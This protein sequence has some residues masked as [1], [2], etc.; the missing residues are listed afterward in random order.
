MDSSVLPVTTN[1][2]TEDFKQGALNRVDNKTICW[3][4][5]VD[6]FVTWHH[7]PEKLSNFLDYLTSIHCNIQFTLATKP[8]QN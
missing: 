7:V 6:T 3:F 1:F 8:S 5:Y 2:F 4:K